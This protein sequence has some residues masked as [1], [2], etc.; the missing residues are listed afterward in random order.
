MNLIDLIRNTINSVLNTRNFTDIMPGEVTSIEPLKISIMDGQVELD[1]TCLIL[2]DAVIRKEIRIKP[3]MHYFEKD[4]FKHNHGSPL[5]F[6]KSID[7]QGTTATQ[8]GTQNLNVISAKVE[9]DEG[10]KDIDLS[11]SGDEIES[12]LNRKSTEDTLEVVVNGVQIPLSKDPDS[13]EEEDDES[14]PVYWGVLNHGLYPGD[15][16]LLL[17]CKEGS[18]FVVLSRLYNSYYYRED[19]E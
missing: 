3:H 6:P 18:R 9:F 8:L 5:Q 15:G 7:I 17:R 13:E 11:D 10:S 4:M 2:T 19:E 12:L 14:S 1:E 16:V